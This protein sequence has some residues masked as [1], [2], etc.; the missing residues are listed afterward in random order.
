[1]TLA[2]QDCKAPEMTESDP[3]SASDGECKAQRSGQVTRDLTGSGA[4][5]ELGPRALDI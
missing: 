4:E 2:C 3:T 5:L 1:M